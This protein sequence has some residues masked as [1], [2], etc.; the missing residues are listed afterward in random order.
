MTYKEIVKKI[1]KGQPLNQDEIKFLSE[2][3]I[4]YIDFWYR[5]KRSYKRI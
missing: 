5:Q 3:E 1:K 4:V 2:L